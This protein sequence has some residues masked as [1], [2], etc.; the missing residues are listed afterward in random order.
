MAPLGIDF[1]R[2]DICSGTN[3]ETGAFPCSG[4][5]D[6]IVAYHGSIN[7]SQPVGYKVVMYKFKGEGA[8]RL[9]TGEFTDVIYDLDATKTFR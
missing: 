1:F 6:A 9:P 2:G 4:K 7:I 5:G 3:S 8:N